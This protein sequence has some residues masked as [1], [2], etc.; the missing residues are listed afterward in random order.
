MRNKNETILLLSLS[1]LVHDFRHC[2][3]KLAAVSRAGATGVIESGETPVSFDAPKSTTPTLEDSD[4]RTR[5]FESDILGKQI[6]VTRQSAVAL[7]R[8]HGL[9]STATWRRLKTTRT[10]WKVY[11]IDVRGKI[12][13]THA[14]EGCRK[15]NVIRSLRS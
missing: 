6:F 12:L 8:K 13:G 5:S 2:R 11:A 1:G 9:V 10:V 15:L 14:S 7:N 3:A 4:S